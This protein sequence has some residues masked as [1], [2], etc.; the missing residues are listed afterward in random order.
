MRV[1]SQKGHRGKYTEQPPIP[2]AVCCRSAL[3]RFQLERRAQ[4]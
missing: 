2:M 3:I 4:R 1:C